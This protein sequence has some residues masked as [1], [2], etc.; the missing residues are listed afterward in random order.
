MYLLLREIAVRPDK[1]GD[2]NYFAQ[3]DCKFPVANDMIL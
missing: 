2:S 1:S 3:R